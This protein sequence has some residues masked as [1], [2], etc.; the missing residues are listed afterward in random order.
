VKLSLFELRVPC[1]IAI[2]HAAITGARTHFGNAQ[3]RPV[4]LFRLTVRIDYE[5]GFRLHR[6]AH[7]HPGRRSH[8][9]VVVEFKPIRW[10]ERWCWLPISSSCGGLVFSARPLQRII[11]RNRL[12]DPDAHPALPRRAALDRIRP[13]GMSAASVCLAARAALRLV[14]VHSPSF[15]LPLD[16]FRNSAMNMKTTVRKTP[17]SEATFANGSKPKGIDCPATRP[18]SARFVA[19][20]DMFSETSMNE[21]TDVYWLSTNRARSHWILWQSYFDDNWCV[22]EHQVYAY[23]P[24]RGRDARQAALALLECGWRAEREAGHLTDPPEA[25]VRD[26]LLSADEIDRLAQ[27]IWPE[28]DS[29]EDSEDDSEPKPRP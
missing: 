7:S 21:R 10:R 24:R 3:A 2:P 23:M 17:A 29:Q 12:Q 1:T 6:S 19:K 14:P 16:R 13:K 9:Q 11:G 27:S 26:G 15:L 22:W 25:I 28:R 20:V 5:A 8:A 18:K 4:S